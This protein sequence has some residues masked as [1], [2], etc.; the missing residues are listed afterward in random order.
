MNSR[1]L[2]FRIYRDYIPP[3]VNT[4]TEPIIF[5]DASRVTIPTQN[6]QDFSRMSNALLPHVIKLITAN[7]LAL[8][9][10]NQT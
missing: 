7:N 8:N 6:F 10:D 2:A 9:L 3:T 5:A 1:T 4:L